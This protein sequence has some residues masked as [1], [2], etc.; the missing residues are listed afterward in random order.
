[1]AGE[2]S[3]IFLFMGLQIVIF[4]GF[5]YSGIDFHPLVGLGIINIVPGI[6]SIGFLLLVNFVFASQGL[7]EKNGWKNKV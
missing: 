4:F 6:I 7:G 2:F 5:I 1:M 3:S